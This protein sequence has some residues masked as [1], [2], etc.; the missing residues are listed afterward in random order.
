MCE[1]SQADSSGIGGKVG[2][3]G[4]PAVGQCALNDFDDP[5]E[6]QKKKEK[7]EGPFQ[8][9]GGKAALPQSHKTETRIHSQM[10]QLVHETEIKDPGFGNAFSGHEAEKGNDQSQQQGEFVLKEVFSYAQHAK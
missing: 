3:F 10:H 9:G 2:Q 6:S 7:G 1:A 4:S 5:A 8:P